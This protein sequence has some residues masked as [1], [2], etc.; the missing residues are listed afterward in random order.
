MNDCWAYEARKRPDFFQLVERFSELIKTGDP[1]LLKPMP[2]I[3]MAELQSESPVKL[4]TYD[5]SNGDARFNKGYV[6]S[7][8]NNKPKAE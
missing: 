2:Q 8:I 1:S 7:E 3:Y 5:R 6:L 4:R